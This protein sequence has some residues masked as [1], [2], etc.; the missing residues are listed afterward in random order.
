MV[1]SSNWRICDPCYLISQWG[2]GKG[3]CRQPHVCAC[4]VRM[5][6]VCVCV[7]VRE[8]AREHWTVIT[9]LKTCWAH[10]KLRSCLPIKLLISVCQSNHFTTAD[11]LWTS[12]F[13]QVSP[14]S[15]MVTKGY[16]SWHAFSNIWKRLLFTG[17]SFAGAR[18]IDLVM[19]SLTN[20][21]FL[22]MTPGFKA[23]LHISAFV[24]VQCVQKWLR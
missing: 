19:L 5:C 20:E 2:T 22:W 7:S 10:A 24:H 13:M 12:E 11:L 9:L 8:R 23:N 16:F 3:C 1:T 15:S 18:S 14:F 4:A 6:I 21:T 17:D